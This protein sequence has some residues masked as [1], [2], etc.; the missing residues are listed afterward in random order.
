M[1]LTLFRLPAL[2]TFDNRWTKYIDTSVNPRTTHAREI[3]LKSLSSDEIFFV[4]DDMTALAI[5]AY[6]FVS[7]TGQNA[8]TRTMYQ[9][10]AYGAGAGWGP[11][12][13]RLADVH[14]FTS[15]LPQDALNA[16]TIAALNR[17]E[18]LAGNNAIAINDILGA[19]TGKYI[20]LAGFSDREDLV[21]RLDYQFRELGDK[22]RVPTGTRADDLKDV[23]RYG[24]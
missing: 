8:V 13:T 23:A 1:S 24:T 4:L 9:L 12:L 11:D 10:A 5:E 22:T 7:G 17:K 16:G 2:A 21:E 18:G 20:L 3:T 14:R 15:A 6:T 19:T